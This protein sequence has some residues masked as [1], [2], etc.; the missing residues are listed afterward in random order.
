[1]LLEHNGV[2]FN[3][4]KFHTIQKDYW[5]IP[6]EVKVFNLTFTELLG[7][8]RSLTSIMDFDSQTARDL[9][10]DEIATNYCD[11]I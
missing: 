3:V 2:I 10:Y 5:E 1:M 11:R 9:A 8:E 7:D 6:G 4:S